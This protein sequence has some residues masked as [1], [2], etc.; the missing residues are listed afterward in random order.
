MVRMCGGAALACM[1]RSLTD[2]SHCTTPLT[3]HHQQEMMDQ[4]E[5]IFESLGEKENQQ[6]HAKTVASVD[7]A[8]Y[9]CEK[10]SKDGHGVCT[11]VPP[12]VLNPKPQTPPT[13]PTTHPVRAPLGEVAQALPGAGAPGQ[14]GADEKALL[15]LRQPE[16]RR[17]GVP[18]RA[19][20]APQGGLPQV[21]GAALAGAREG[22][23][24]QRRG[25]PG[26]GRAGAAGGGHRRLEP[27]RRERGRVVRLGR[28]E[29]AVQG[30][31]SKGNGKE[32][33]RGGGF[34][35]SRSRVAFNTFTYICDL[36]AFWCVLGILLS[37]ALAH[38]VRRF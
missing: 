15:R 23:A 32:R 20:D 14:E 33:G 9:Q 6:E 4:M 11:H 3:P 29:A 17:P 8:A 7:V 38:A 13:H 12:S 37:M 27:V 36:A 16:L 10:A 22:E 1:A 5:S 34:R 31:A 2:M 18:A 35:S 28:G 30:K 25:R 19:R 24:A 21:R 26:Q